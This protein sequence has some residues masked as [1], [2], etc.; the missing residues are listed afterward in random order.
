[1]SNHPDILPAHPEPAKS[2]RQLS[3]ERGV[4]MGGEWFDLATPEHFW[5]ARRFEVLRKL[6]G[7]RLTGKIQCGE[8]G[9]GNGVLQSQIE[10]EYGLAVDGFDLHRGALEQNI[11]SRGQLHYYD[12]SERHPEFQHRY[13]VLFVFDVIEH[14]TG[15]DE[16]LQ[17]CRFHLRPGGALL[18]NVP[19]RPEL[20]S[21]YDVAAGHVRRYTLKQLRDLAG[22]TA[23][24]LAEHT[25]W[26]LPYYPLLLARKMMQKR[27]SSA[28]V[29]RA[30]FSPRAK[31]INTMLL[32]LA[33][34]EPI[35]QRA[36]GT[37]LLAVFQNADS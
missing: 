34:A 8:I 16:F 9:C 3:V 26:G 2:F 37:S 28:S 20:F 13:D 7:H 12:I 14:V 15:E 18:I 22:R 21:T 25:Y 1:M 23:M 29:L 5:M 24:R 4:S 33:R 27:G 36:L 6:C 32:W 17:A 10:A 11:S 35:P 19:A 31:A 30:G